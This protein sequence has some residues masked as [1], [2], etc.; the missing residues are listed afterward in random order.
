MTPAPLVLIVDDEPAMRAFLTALLTAHELQV[1]SASSCREADLQ[2]TT[3][4][5]ELVLLDLG[6][7]DG[8]GIDWVRRFRAWSTAPVVVLSAREREHDKVE[9]LDAGADDYL[10]KPF[11]AGELMARVRVALRHRATSANAPEPVFRVG[12]LEVDRARR[13]LRVDGALV[14]LTQTEWKLLEL[15]TRHAG[16]VLTHAQILR[17]VWGPAHLRQTHYVRVHVHALRRKIERDANE[18]RHLVT[19]TGVGYRLRDEP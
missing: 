11:G 12:D 8:D 5:P 9:A 1:V 6:L 18:P 2:A 3:R 17:E 7:P 13:E 10:T 4:A 16:R 19:E 15:F 14:P